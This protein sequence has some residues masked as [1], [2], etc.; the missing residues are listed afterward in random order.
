MGQALSDVER[1]CERR[2]RRLVQ[3]AHRGREDRQQ[4][5]IHAR[6]LCVAL[7]P[8]LGAVGLGD[9]L[10]PGGGIV[11]VAGNPLAQL[12]HPL[13]GHRGPLLTAGLLSVQRLRNSPALQQQQLAGRFKMDLADRDAAQGWGDG[14]LQAPPFARQESRAV[15][16]LA[17][18][19]AASLPAIQSSTYDRPPIAQVLQVLQAPSTKW[20]SRLAPPAPWAGS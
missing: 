19:P 5:L 18:P 12:H 1:C 8:P 2:R 7:G 11:G 15:L 4:V 14:L 10:L 17:S 16:R 3:A 6:Q 13:L 9:E 20:P